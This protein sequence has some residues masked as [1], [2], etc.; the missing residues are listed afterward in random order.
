MLQVGKL[1][2]NSCIRKSVN[3]LIIFNHN[4]NLIQGSLKVE[5]NVL[6]IYYNLYSVGIE[7]HTK[8]KCQAQKQVKTTKY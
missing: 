1:I 7:F 2:K 3:Y 6:Q 4:R 5:L 8:K